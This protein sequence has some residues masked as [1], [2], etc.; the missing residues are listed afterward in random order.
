MV[1]LHSFILPIVALAITSP[2]STPTIT[3][4]KANRN[5]LE[6][7]DSLIYGDY[8]IPYPSASLPDESATDTFIFR[9]LDGGDEIGEIVPYALIDKGYNNGVFS[10][11]FS[12]S[13][14]LDWGQAYTIRISENPSYFTTPASFDYVMPSSAWS[15]LTDQEANQLELAIN[16]LNAANRLHTAY[17]AYSFTEFQPSGTV[18]SEPIGTTYFR[19]AIYGIQAMAPSLFLVQILQNPST[20]ANYTTAQFDLY[21]Q[22]FSTT[23]V[24]ASENATA[25]QF[26]ITPTMVLGMLFI[27]PLCI[28]SII[29]SSMKFHQAEPGFVTCAILLIL[30]ALMGWIPAAVFASTYQ[31]LGIYIAYVWFYARG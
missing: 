25:N 17:S 10:F 8:D 18:L 3:N 21:R 12:A 19:G 28:G 13:D 31:A 11:Y 30:G 1:F 14:N 27:F 2:T 5:L 7:G 23:W 15:I 24:G 26:G 4:I 16:I 9:L 6:L 22:R 29:L 20:S